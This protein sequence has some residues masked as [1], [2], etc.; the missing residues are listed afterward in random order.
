MD[1]RFY[2]P[3]KNKNGNAIAL[4][5]REKEIKKGEKTYKE[6]QLFI[7]GAQQTGEDANGNASFGWKDKDKCV[8]LKLGDADVG[9]MLAVTNR[10]KDFVGRDASK[11]LFH[12]NAQG[13][14]S[15][16]LAKNDNGEGYKL[17]VSSKRGDKLVAVTMTLSFG[18]I[19]LLANVLR[20]YLQNNLM[21]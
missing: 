15:L 16:Q 11:G 14:S 18:D 8:T 19:E 13:N 7:V 2:R 9:E 1:T 10:R 17:R 6:W 5:L 21:S 4:E 20:T 3:N 12:Q